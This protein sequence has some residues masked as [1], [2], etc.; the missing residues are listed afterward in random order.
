MGELLPSLSTP[1]LTN[2]NSINLPKRL[3]F[4]FLMVWA[5]PN[6]SKMGL[7]W[8]MRSATLCSSPTTSTSGEAIAVKYP[9]HCFVASVL[10]APDSPDI[11]IDWFCL[12]RHR[13]WYAREGI[14]YT[15]D[16]N[17]ILT[18]G[19][20]D[21]LKYLSIISGPIKLGILWKGFNARTTVPIDV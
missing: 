11:N 3:E 16:G 10:P 2:T 17:T 20:F 6:A 19:V 14:W 7:D 1:L 21:C 4:G 15:W 8:M 12:Y 5:L 13:S 9:K 18:E